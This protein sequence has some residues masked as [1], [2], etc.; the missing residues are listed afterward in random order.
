MHAIWPKVPSFHYPS[1]IAYRMRYYSLYEWAESCQPKIFS[2]KIDL[3]DIRNLMGL[4]NVQHNRTLSCLAR[5][6]F[7][8]QQTSITISQHSFRAMDNAPNGA[9][10]RMILSPLREK[11]KSVYASTINYL[12]EVEQSRGSSILVGQPNALL[13]SSTTTSSLP[14]MLS[15]S[16]RLTLPSLCLV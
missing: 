16:F 11:Q 9:L 1:P 10:V 8:V 4:Y 7:I 5:Q 2:R 14:R 6:N 3:E 13:I 12:L 15:H